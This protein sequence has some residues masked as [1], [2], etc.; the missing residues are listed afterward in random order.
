MTTRALHSQVVIKLPRSPTMQMATDTGKYDYGG[1]YFVTYR[2]N[3]GQV[4]RLP[5]VAQLKP[6]CLFA[7]YLFPAFSFLP[8]RACT[9]FAAR[10]AQCDARAL[11]LFLYFFVS[12]R[13]WM[14]LTL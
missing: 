13:Q 4:G 10:F 12:N 5:N 8:S 9:V 1:S 14:L 3:S 2:T 7:S 6:D 11:F